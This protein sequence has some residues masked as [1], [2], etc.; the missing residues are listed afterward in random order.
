MEKSSYI[1]LLSEGG[2]LDVSEKQLVGG[3]R[4]TKTHAQGRAKDH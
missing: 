3:L 2:A 1:Q 4:L